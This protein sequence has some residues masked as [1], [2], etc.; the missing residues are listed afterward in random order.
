MWLQLRLL[1][2]YITSQLNTKTQLAKLIIVLFCRII[3]II[4]I[5]V[6][7]NGKYKKLLQVVT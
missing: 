3:C 4:E 6:H 2:A 1:P 7:V 5:T